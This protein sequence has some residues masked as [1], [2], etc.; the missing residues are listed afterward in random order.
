MAKKLC[1]IANVQI[2]PKT[3]RIIAKNGYVCPE[4]CTPEQMLRV[5][6]PGLKVVKFQISFRL[7]FKTI[8]F[9][10][11]IN[12]FSNNFMQRICFANR[13]HTRYVAQNH[14]EFFSL[15]TWIAL[16]CIH[17]GLSR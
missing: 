16:K 9:F 14:A 8:K 6:F 13:R 1:P 5:L 11:H 4:I 3:R 17:L 2:L 12:I 7:V 15:N 10:F